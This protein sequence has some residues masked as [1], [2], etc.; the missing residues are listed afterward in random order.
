MNICAKYVILF[1]LR[2]IAIIHITAQYIYIYIFF[3]YYLTY[4]QFYMQNIHFFFFYGHICIFMM[5]SIYKGLN[6]T[7]FKLEI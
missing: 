6:N 4:M 5:L 1:I 2:F 7:I 3:S